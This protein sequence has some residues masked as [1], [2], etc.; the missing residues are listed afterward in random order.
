MASVSGQSHL[1]R[2]SQNTLRIAC[3]PARLQSPSASPSSNRADDISSASAPREHRS[4]ASATRHI[5]SEDGGVQLAGLQHLEE[6]LAR[7]RPLHE[8]RIL[9]F[10]DMS[11][12]KGNPLQ[13]FRRETELVM[14][15]PANPDAGGLAVGAHTNP[16]TGKIGWPFNGGVSR[17]AEK[18]SFLKSR[19]HGYR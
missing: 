11:A 4:K 2:P 8:G 16:L 1:T 17:A 12:F 7:F 18:R 3:P 6:I 5:I 15:Y 14:Q 13:V 19:E 10:P 9:E